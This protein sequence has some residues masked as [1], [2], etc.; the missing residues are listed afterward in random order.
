MRETYGYIFPDPTASDPTSE[1]QLA[2]DRAGEIGGILCLRG[3][4][5]LSDTVYLHAETSV[6][7]EDAA[8]FSD[9]GAPIF[10]NSVVRTVRE[11]T[12]LGCQ[13]GIS[14]Y[15]KDSTLYG[16]IE[17]F[18]VRNFTID[19]LTFSGAGAKLT[20]MYASGGEVRHLSFSG[21]DT[22]IEC[23]ICT[24]NCFFTDIHAE[25]G[26]TL[27]LFDSE[28]L[29]AARRVNYA[30]PDV[31]NIIVRDASGGEIRTAGDYGSDLV[32]AD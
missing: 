8:L 10:K 7:L 31:K 21:A 18:N 23:K 26:E 12:K 4:W 2:A 29:P 30:G 3:T 1:L 28:R 32:I 13:S 27:F 19:G 15:G 14:L 6:R 25:G 5:H 17:L 16:A 9:S 11:R 24:R 20:L 22:A